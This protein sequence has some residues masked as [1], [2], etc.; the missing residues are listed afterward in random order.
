MVQFAA[1]AAGCVLVIL[2]NFARVGG[3]AR[4]VSPVACAVASGLLQVFPSSDT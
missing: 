1:F 3:N 4:I 2:M